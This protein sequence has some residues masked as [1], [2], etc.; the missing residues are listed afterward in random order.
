MRPKERKSQAILTE[1]SFMSSFTPRLVA[2][3]TASNKYYRYPGYYDGSINGVNNC[4]LINSST[5]AVMPNCVGY[6]WG[7]VYELLGRVPALSQG[8]AVTWWGYPDGY[9]RSPLINGYAGI[10]G[11][12]LGA[13]ACMDLASPGHIAVVEEHTAPY[14]WTISESIYGGAFFRLGTIAWNS[15]AQK[16]FCWYDAAGGGSVNPWDVKGF[17]YP[18]Y[19]WYNVGQ[20]KF[21]VKRKTERR[22]ILYV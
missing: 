5:G 1:V 3:V 17:I 11:P 6:A 15:N 9:E 21:F 12:R 7:R 18:P 14:E 20:A 2:P 4:L 16:W 13:V 22:R 8:D 19:D 10:D